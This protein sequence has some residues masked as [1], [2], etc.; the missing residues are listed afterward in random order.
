MITMQTGFYKLIVTITIISLLFVL[1]S[2]SKNLDVPYPANSTTTA[3]AFNSKSTI[4][5]MM[6][7]LLI[8][9]VQTG[10]ST[11]L[12][13]FMPGLSDE[14]YNPTSY[15]P[16][17]D[18]CTNNVTPATDNV[19]NWNGMYAT[20]YTANMLLEGI[21]GSIVPGFTESN[22]KAYL[23]SIKTIRAY[24]Y[25]M[26]TRQYGDVPLVLNTNVPVNALLPREAGTKVYA[27][28]EKDLQEAVADLPAA[29]N[30][31]YYINNKF[32]PEAILAEV[33]LT[34]KKWALAEAAAS[35]IINSGNYKLAALA[36]VFLQSGNEGIIVAPPAASFNANGNF[37][38]GNS[39]YQI[40]LPQGVGQTMLES[41]SIALSPG[42]LASFEP[43]DERLVNWVTLL[44]AG[45]YPNAANRMFCY[46]YKYNFVFYEGTIPPG[47]EEEDQIIRFAEI[48]LIRAEARAEQNNLNAAKD[49]LNMIRTRAG[50]GNT[51]A[52]S[53]AEMITAVLNE[54]RHELFFE[55]GWRWF[56]LVRTGRANAVLNPIT[57]K[58]NWKHHMLLFPLSPTILSAN[59]NLTQTPGY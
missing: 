57:Y 13:R 50:L 19:P 56:D 27:A 21:P 7:N 14:G 32:M 54:R 40:G 45:G 46:K 59:P 26:L 39:A 44:N 25:F 47:R 5:G 31:K 35:D 17:M 58:T 8:Q 22:K 18:A 30:V 2:C 4:D 38:V 43:G 9:F 6:N 23:A 33:Y 29:L 12:L 10:L 41:S 15:G 52:A 36:D 24:T 34:E 28:I 42:L 48:Y 3:T 37:K 49:D 1:G 11:Q 55:G 20:I 16:F 51:T 53:Q